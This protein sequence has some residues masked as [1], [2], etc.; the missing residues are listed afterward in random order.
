MD[1][2]GSARARSAPNSLTGRHPRPRTLGYESL[3]RREVLAGNV[4][5]VLTEGT[6]TI[7]GDAEGNGINIRYDANTK[8][9]IVSGTDCGGEP[10][11][12]NDLAEDAAFSGVRSIIVRGGAGND[13]LDFGAVD[14]LFTRVDKKLTIMMGDGD[15]TVELG[16]AGHTDAGDGPVRSRMYVGKGVYVDLG[17]GDDQLDVANLKSNKSLIVQGRGGD[18]TISFKTELVEPDDSDPETEE[19]TQYFPV[20]VRGNLHL[21]MSSGE[22]TVDIKHT[23][24]KLNLH[25]QDPQDTAKISLENVAVGGTLIVNTGK[26]ADEIE[27]DHVSAKQVKVKTGSGGDEVTIE[28]SRAKRLYVELEGG[29]DK[30]TLRRSRTTQTTYLNGGASGADLTQSGNVLRGLVRRRFS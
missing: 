8:K 26:A 21:Y 14:H 10:T 18:D 13:R 30:L 1:R 19:E 12:V 3:E 29:E 20:E 22:D 4:V 5:A 15:D 23:A 7:L 9:H 24:V 28:H 16:R 6:L 27:L 2:S 11:L 17:S 25:I